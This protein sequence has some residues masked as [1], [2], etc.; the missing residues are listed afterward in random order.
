MAVVVEVAER[1]PHRRKHASV[2]IAAHEG[3]I[4]LAETKATILHVAREECIQIRIVG[5]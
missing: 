2:Q 1:N 3:R 4:S 5:W